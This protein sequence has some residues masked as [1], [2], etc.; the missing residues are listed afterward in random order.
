MTSE[1]RI[2]RL[3]VENFRNIE[4]LAIEL[5]PHINVIAGDNGHGK[6]SVLEA[7]YFVATSRSFRTERIGE[8]QREGA[9]STRV[10]ARLAEAAQHR[11]QRAALVSG[12]RSLA[13]DGKRPQ[14]VAKFAVRTPVVVFH[15][16]DLQL[17]SGGAGL[18]RTLLDRVSL[19][20]DP[21]RAEARSRYGKAQKQRQQVLQQRGARAKE[22]DVFEDLMAQAG[23]EVAVGRQLATEALRSAL[24]D[25]FSELAAADLDLELQLRMGGC[26]DPTLFR[27]ELFERRERDLQRRAASFGPQRDDL[28]LTLNGRSARRHAS[29]GQQRIL[30]LAL[31]VAELD[32]VRRARGAHPLLLLDDV[33]SELDPERTGAV[34]RFVRSATNQVLVTTTRPELFETPGLGPLD[35]ADFRLH[36]GRLTQP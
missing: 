12:R 1:L 36:Q 4:R 10:A 21:H 31:K 34:Y 17:V 23:T 18:R 6:T 33:S 13:L 7:V 32:C 29:Q 2:E 25:V 19:F 11:V 5:A 9:T 20:Q 27:R 3:E 26:T 35:R 15:P 30:T 16:G 24:A 22:L 8:V 14:S 28:E